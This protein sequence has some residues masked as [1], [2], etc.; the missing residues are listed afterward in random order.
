MKLFRIYHKII[1]QVHVNQTNILHMF[2]TMCF[3]VLTMHT[4][5]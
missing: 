4:W 5:N 1:L 2:I 3:Q